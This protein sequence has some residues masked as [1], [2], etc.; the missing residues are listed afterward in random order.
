MLNIFNWIVIGSFVIT[1]L[2]GGT[3]AVKSAAPPA[4]PVAMSLESTNEDDDGEPGYFQ[5]MKQLFLTILAEK[6]GI[7]P[8][9][10]E[11]RLKDGD[12]LP[13][14]AEEQGMSKQELRDLLWEAGYE[15]ID[16]AVQEN[17]LTQ[18]QADLLREK[19]EKQQ[20]DQ[21]PGE[22]EDIEALKDLLK[23]VTTEQLADELGISVEEVKKKL[24]EG[25]S[26]VQI[27]KEGGLD[28][29][30]LRDL[31]RDA[32]SSAL[33]QALEQGLLTEEQAEWIQEHSG[34]ILKFRM[35]RNGEADRHPF[36]RFFRF[37]LP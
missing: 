7:D 30:D 10:L 21:F 3:V 8:Q 22:I 13:E 1:S 36:G 6:L 35:H 12:T 31:L 20:E 33:E 34:K 26:F 32:R 9:D 27:A 17:L 18:K 14:I 11:E 23:E 29:S 4:Q 37:R 2:F 25:M 19:L 28:R 16:R 5:E 24:E 15:F